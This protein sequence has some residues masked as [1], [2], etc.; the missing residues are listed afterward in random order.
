MFVPIHSLEIRST[1]SWDETRF[2]GFFSLDDKV[3]ESKLVPM[4]LCVEV[5]D[6]REDAMLCS[7]D[8]DSGMVEELR[9]CLT[10]SKHGLVKTII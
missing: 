7:G 1:S 3:L 6:V 4:V 8:S 2:E 10:A 5:L 9:V